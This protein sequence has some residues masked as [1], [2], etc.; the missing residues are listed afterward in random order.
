MKSFIS[1][2]MGRTHVLRLDPGDMV[3]E[4]IRSLVAEKGIYNAYIASGIGT[5]DRCR[6]YMVA[7]TG[8]PMEKHHE[9][10]EDT[11]LEIASI[12]GFIAGGEPHLHAVVSDHR[13]AYA[14]HVEEGCRVLYLCEIVIQEIEGP[15]LKRIMNEKGVNVLEG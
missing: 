12:D 11:P 7:T 6:L 8:Y 4:S 2:K 9:K 14:G 1:G 5:L 3:L 13:Q 15:A 10:W